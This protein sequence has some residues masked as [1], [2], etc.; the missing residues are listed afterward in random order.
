MLILTSPICCVFDQVFVATR[1]SQN[2]VRYDPQRWGTTWPWLLLAGEDARMST[3]CDEQQPPKSFA[4]RI[5]ISWPGG[6][7]EESVQMTVGIKIIFGFGDS[8]VVQDM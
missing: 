2:S 3:F 7:R 1:T 4:Y 5:S 8:D 6:G